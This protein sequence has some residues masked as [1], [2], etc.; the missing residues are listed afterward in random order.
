MS[1]NKPVIK[2]GG[3]SNGVDGVVEPPSAKKASGWAQEKPPYQYHNWLQY[4][5][6]LWI[7]YLYDLN[8]KTTD[9]FNLD[10]NNNVATFTNSGNSVVSSYC[11]SGSIGANCISGSIKNSRSLGV[12]NCENF[13]ILDSSNLSVTGSKITGLTLKS[14]SIGTIGSTGDISNIKITNSNG[15]T[16][17]GSDVEIENSDTIT[18][19]GNKVSVKNSSNIS[20]P[21]GVERASVTGVD[22]FEETRNNVHTVTDH[23]VLGSH[24]VKK[25]IPSTLTEKLGVANQKL[26]GNRYLSQQAFLYWPCEGVDPLWRSVYSAGSPVAG[27]DIVSGAQ[28]S[29]A[30]YTKCTSSINVNAAAQFPFGFASVYNVTY[31]H[32]FSTWL[33]CKDVGD[34]ANG[35]ICTFG[36]DDNIGANFGW[37]I[38]RREADAS[39]VAGGINSTSV[40][41]LGPYLDEEYFHLCVVWDYSRRLFMFYIDGE[42][43]GNILATAPTIG[44]GEVRF[45]I[46]QFSAGVPALGPIRA[47]ETSYWANTTF[48]GH[49][50]KKLY[51]GGV[52]LASADST[53]FA[54]S[55]LSTVHLTNTDSRAYEQPIYAGEDDYKFVYL[56]FPKYMKNV[57][58]DTATKIEVYSEKYILE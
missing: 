30:L 51:C 44:T 7:D 37:I 32:V 20:I 28:D 40:V 4:V 33:L 29:D 2:I 31:P 56:E 10:F 47:S 21:V 22:D 12:L 8:F 35:S 6:A 49:D 25:V 55:K 48:T 58:H 11:E 52:E 5:V 23:R 45:N 15:F 24:I 43:K 46:G 41:D 19:H 3:W 50:V 53:L 27:Y 34:A 18:I 16:V 13:E 36:C 54:N 26:F 17:T 42:H 39:L 1:Q 38:A 9:T 57:L 14:S